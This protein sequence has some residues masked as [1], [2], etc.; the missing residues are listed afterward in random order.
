VNLLAFATETLRFFSEGEDMGAHSSRRAGQ[1]WRVVPVAFLLAFLGLACSVASAT[2]PAYTDATVGSV[3]FASAGGANLGS[4][5]NAT[6]ISADGSNLSADVDTYG[7]SYSATALADA[8]VAPGSTVTSNGF[9]FTWPDVDPGTSDSY[10]ASG[11]TVAVSIPA[12][13]SSLG[14][15]GAAVNAGTS[16]SS[17]TLTIHYSNGTTSTATLSFPD[18]TLGG[19]SGSLP[20]GTTEA[21]TTSYRNTSSGTDTENTYVF[22]VSIPVTSSKTVVSVTFPSS[23]S[24]GPLYVFAFG[25]SSATYNNAGISADGHGS[26]ANFDGDGDSYSATALANA[27]IQAGSTLSSNGFTFT[28]PDV[29]SGTSDNYQASGQT[30]AVSIPSGASSLGV[31]GTAVNAGTSG[32][33]GTVTINYSNGTTSTATLSFPDW[34]LGGGSGSL[35]SGTTEAITTSYRNTSSGTQTEN[36]YVFAVSIPV[37]PSKTVVSVTLPSSGSNGALHVFAFGAAGFDSNSLADSASNQPRW[38]SYSGGRYVLNPQGGEPYSNPIATNLPVEEAAWFGDNE[39]WSNLL[40]VG[41]APTGDSTASA[42]STTSTWYPYQLGFTANYASPSGATISGEDYFTDALGTMIRSMVVTASASTNLTLSGTIPSGETATWNSTSDVLEVSGSSWG[43]VMRFAQGEWPSTLTAT[44]S[45]SGSTWTLVEPLS[46]GSTEIDVSMAWWVS[47]DTTA[48]AISR[49][50]NALSIAIPESLHASKSY[51]DLLLSQV[52]QP[53][54][55][56]VNYVNPMGVGTASVT[57]AES[58]NSYFRAWTFLLQQVENP[59]PDYVAEG[60]SYPQISLGKPALLNDEDYAPT[61]S[62]ASWDTVL[63]AEDLAYVPSEAENAFHALQG[64]LSTEQ[65]SGEIDGEVL[66]TRFAQAAWTLYE[67]TGDK[68]TLSALYPDLK[69]FLLYMYAHPCWSGATDQDSKDLEYVASW[70]VDAQYAEDIAGVLGDSSDVSLYESDASTY[71]TDM[72][73]WFFS[74]P[75]TVYQTYYADTDTNAPADDNTANAVLSALAVPG[76]SSSYETQL[77]NYFYNNFA[78]PAGDE[79]IDAAA[80]GG[81][82]ANKYPDMSLIAQGLI[83]DTT[84]RM[85]EEFVNAGVR[86]AV[87]PGDFSELDQPGNGLTVNGGIMPSDFSAMQVIDFTL[88]QND[89]NMF[90][91]SPVAFAIDPGTDSFYSGFETGQPVPTLAGLNG[92]P[93][94]TPDP[95]G[96]ISGVTGICCSLS[97]PETAVYPNPL[98]VSSGVEDLTYSGYDAS[99]QTDHAY[100]EAFNFASDPIVVSSSTHLEFS[101]FPQSNATS[102]YVSGDN[103]ECTTVDIVFSDGTVLRNLGAVDQYGVTMAPQDMCGTLPLDTWT[104]IISDIGAVAAGKSIIRIGVGYQMPD[105]PGGGYR[106]LIDDISVQ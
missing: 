25:S 67:Q 70:L 22:A 36:T 57:S 61:A 2:T 45:I 20:S 32:S 98:S 24:N 42:T 105:S 64:L 89:A 53:S 86:D 74:N 14:V 27:G 56:G 49:A 92:N 104:R 16:G 7:D 96:G 38:L 33:S 95:T 82:I 48:N 85:A 35:P 94:G 97:G 17:G 65:S 99:G 10:L 84:G 79:G 23:G 68:A 51:M 12:G 50:I 15:L 66:P 28:W 72:G 26:T 106:G 21:I 102:G 19:G 43:Y 63:A 8:G 81:N 40:T 76:L 80:P 83:N 54:T 44:A 103:S 46:S 69:Q 34:T 29:A 78:F 11:Q 101:I 18:W 87:F 5:Y 58:Q 9:S 91:G 93:G 75:D 55:F 13:S 6:A 52:P 39:A 47:P 77:L 3:Q 73:T 41:L 1:V 37:T 60:F 31:L 59:F 88:L 90:S 71:M 100:T 30:I 62:E 4:Y